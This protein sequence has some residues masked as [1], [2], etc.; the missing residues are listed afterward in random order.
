MVPEGRLG[1]Q[2]GARIRDDSWSLFVRCP[3]SQEHVDIHEYTHVDIS[4][5]VFSSTLDEYEDLVSFSI[6][7]WSLEIKLL[8]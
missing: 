6:G 8:E 3:K 4:L 2:F 7:C 1:R 5:I